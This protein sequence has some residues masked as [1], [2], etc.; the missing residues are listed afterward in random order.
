MKK[1]I[2]IG[3]LLPVLAY[4]QIDYSKMLIAR[5]TGS[6]TLA[7]GQVI[8]TMGFALGLMDV[9]R[10]PGPL[11]EVNEGDSCHIDLWNISQGAPHTIHLHGLDVDQQNDGVPHLSFEVAHMDHGHYYFKAPHAGTYLYHCHVVSSVHVQAGMYGMLIVHPSDGSQKTWDGGYDYDVSMPIL[12]SEI[13]TVWHHDSIMKHDYDTSMMVHQMELPVYDPQFFLINGF[14][15][16]QIADSSMQLNTSVGAVNYLRFAN[17]GYK[18]VRVIFPSVFGAQ[19]VSSD[20]RP[21][22]SVIS[23]DTLEIYPGERY[24]VLGVFS[25]EGT[26]QF[27]VEYFDLN[28]YQLESTQYLPAVI[29]GYVHQDEWMEIESD[30]E[31]YPNPTNGN[32]TVNSTLYPSKNKFVL[33]DIKGRIMDERIILSEKLQER[34]SFEWTLSDLSPGIYVI[35]HKVGDEVLAIKKLIITF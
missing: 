25:A 20:G 4:G 16:N 13:D 33:M 18:G 6:K 26:D 22:P 3:F 29:Q 31:V 34:Y 8:G 15:D 28:N 9:P 5:N 23:S 17:V 1:W 35:S 2:L 21:L 32:F 7:N 14:S 30:F 27:T 10:I 12:F 24:G 11:I 19:T